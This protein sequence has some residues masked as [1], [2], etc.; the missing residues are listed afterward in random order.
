MEFLSAIVNIVLMLV[1]AAV[2]IMLVSKLNAGLVVEDFKS[3]LIAAAV[4]AIVGGV[5]SWL[6]GLLNLDF[7]ILLRVIAYVIVAAI[8]LL[9]SDKFVKGMKVDGFAGAIMAAVMIATLNWLIT[10]ALGLVF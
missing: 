4:I 3:A 1:F 6:I 8:V 10:W 5:V 7:G 2:I 9:I